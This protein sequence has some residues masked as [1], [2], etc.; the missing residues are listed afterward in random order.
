MDIAPENVLLKC[1]AGER[2]RATHS[3][4][5]SFC[6]VQPAPPEKDEPPYGG[7]RED[8]ATRRGEGRSAAGGWRCV[9]PSAR[10]GFLYDRPGRVWALRLSN[11]YIFCSILKVRR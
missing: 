7:L 3:T 1:N 11:V 9:A 10:P 5:S 4:D 6:L 2:V 8:W